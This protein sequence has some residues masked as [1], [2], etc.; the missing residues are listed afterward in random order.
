MLKWQGLVVH[1]VIAYHDHPTLKDFTYISGEVCCFK[2]TVYLEKKILVVIGYVSGKTVG[3][4][5][6][7]RKEMFMD[8]YLFA[9]RFYGY[10]QTSIDVI[11][12]GDFGNSI[13]FIVVG[14]H[15]YIS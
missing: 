13:N 11:T 8:I 3:Q 10:L 5:Y 2:W 12:T 4:D 6:R 9:P 1:P 7:V 15:F 14:V